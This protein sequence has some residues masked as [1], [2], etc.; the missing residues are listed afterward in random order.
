MKTKKD[1]GSHI[2][3]TLKSAIK[4]PS[5]ELWGRI[6]NSLEQKKKRR[7]FFLFWAMGGIGVLVVG[8]FVLFPL[9]QRMNSASETLEERNHSQLKKELAQPNA[10]DDETLTLETTGDASIVSA[11][12]I[13]E[14]NEKIEQLDTSTNTST[15]QYPEP[16][17]RNNKDTWDR[18]EN[19][20]KT[21]YYYYNSESNTNVSTLQKQELDSLVREK[22]QAFQESLSDSIG[23]STTTSNGIQGNIEV[24]TAIDSLS[25]RQ[26]R[27]LKNKQRRDSILR[28]RDSIRLRNQKK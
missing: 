12:D 20:V 1:I 14:E 17:Q 16:T 8:G 19:K 15:Y 27:V 26:L 3:F 21:T 25:P 23:D 5:S 13:S 22:E 18:Q 28:H 7:R 10:Q 2:E 6:E 4:T 11:V 9:E 24:V